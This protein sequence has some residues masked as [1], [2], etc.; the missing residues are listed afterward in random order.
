MGFTVSSTLDLTSSYW[1]LPVHTDD[2]PKTAFCPGTG[3]GLFQFCKMP[4]GLTGAPAF[5]KD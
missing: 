1:Q 4:F 5:F 3:F 2:H